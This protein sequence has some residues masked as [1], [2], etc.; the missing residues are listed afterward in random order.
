MGR[1][2]IGKRWPRNA[3]L[4][5]RPAMCDYCGVPWRISLMRRDR[6]GRLA[7]PRDIDRRDTFEMAEASARAAEPSSRE[8]PDVESGA[9]PDR[10][11]ASTFAIRTS[12]ADIKA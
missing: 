9:M 4:W 3:P 6:A 7:C 8:R 11:G 10:T 12:R 1:R 2:T 5:D